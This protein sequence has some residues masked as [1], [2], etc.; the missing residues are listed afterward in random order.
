MEI[1]FIYL[2]IYFSNRK[3]SWKRMQINRILTFLSTAMEE[4]IP[5][6]T[7]E[8]HPRSRCSTQYYVDRGREPV[9]IIHDSHTYWVQ[10]SVL[11]GNYKPDDETI[12]EY[13]KLKSNHQCH[14]LFTIHRKS[15]R[16]SVE[17][18]DSE[19]EAEEVDPEQGHGAR[20][21]TTWWDSKMLPQMWRHRQW[22]CFLRF[23]WINTE[24]T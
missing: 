6:L 1:E 24:C 18:R 20:K 19:T 11:Q 7:T 22:Y 4:I 5:F 15:C 2:F 10:I 9:L 16:I 21:T 17:G 3:L 23:L 8:C 14:V 13:Q 12:H